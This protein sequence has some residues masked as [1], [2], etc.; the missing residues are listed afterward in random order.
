MR[1]IHS[2]ATFIV[3]TLLGAAA[4]VQA[5]EAEMTP[6]RFWTFVDNI[7]VTG[8]APE[9]RLWVALPVEHRGQLVEI[10]EIYPEPAAIVEDPLSKTRI[11]FWRQTDIVDGGDLYFY[12]DFKY[13]GELVS[14]ADIDPEKVEPYDEASP[15]YRR[16]TR[17]EPWLEVTDGIR[18]QAR[19][20]V[21]DEVNPYLKAHMIFD[22]VVYN[23]RY[24]F[25]DMESRGAARTFARRSGD[26]AGFS[27]VFCAMCRAEGIPARTVTACW[28]WGAATNGPRCSFRRTA[29][30]RPTRRWRRCSSPAAP[31]RRP[32][33]AF[34]AS[35]R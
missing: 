2:V 7:E 20:I 12:Y 6:G 26:C 23:T 35:W 15:E 16:Y 31:S 8:D 3:L 34:I 14:G 10:G 22:W 1:R 25:P 32:R 27:V 4:A 11:V 24:E 5:E 21:G 30:C 9:V 28:P 13:A 33:I 29:G 17:S 19:E 18:A